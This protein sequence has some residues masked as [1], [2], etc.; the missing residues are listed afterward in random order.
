MR[1]YFGTVTILFLLM[2]T[3]LASKAFS[4]SVIYD[5]HTKNINIAIKERVEKVHPYLVWAD[6]SEGAKGRFFSLV[7]NKGWIS[8]IV[9]VQQEAMD[10]PALGDADIGDLPAECPAGHK[11]FLFMVAVQNG[12]KPHEIEAWKK[13]SIFPL[14][15]EAAKERLPGQSGFVPKQDRFTP[16]YGPTLNL[17]AGGDVDQEKQ[18]DSSVNQTETEKPDIFKIEGQ[19]IF[20]ANANAGRLQVIDWSDPSEPKL[21]SSAEM[22]GNPKEIYSLNGN[23]IIL[24]QSSYGSSSVSNITMVNIYGFKDNE[25]HLKQS[26]K[27]DGLFLESRR[28]GELIYVITKVYEGTGRSDTMP[29]EGQRSMIWPLQSDL[30]VTALKVTPQGWLV[31]KAQKQLVGIPDNA[32]TAIFPNYLLY[33]HVDYAE[34]NKISLITIFD[35][36]NPNNPL[37]QPRH[38]KVPGHIPSEFHMDVQGNIL[39]VVSSPASWQGNKGSTLSIFDLSETPPKLLGKLDGIAPGEDLY[40]TRFET[41]KAYVV[42]YERKDP[43]WVIGLSDSA[44]P[45]ILGHLQV[46][47]WSEK[48]FIHDSKLLGMGVYDQPLPGENRPDDWYRRVAVSLFDVEDPSTPELLDRVVPLADKSIHTSSLALSDERALLLD[49]QRKLC[50]FPVEI[51]GKD[52]GSYLQILTLGDFGLEDRGAVKVPV[53]LKRALFLDDDLLGGLGGFA[54]YTIDW[55]GEPEIA[56][57]LELA[58]DYS[59]LE[60]SGGLVWAA[61]KAWGNNLYKIYGF[62]PDD[63][64]EPVCIFEPESDFK[65]VKINGDMALLY[66]FSPFRITLLDLSSGETSQSFVLDDS[67]NG[68]Y[69]YDNV[70]FKDNKIYAVKTESIGPKEPAPALQSAIFPSP[71]TGYNLSVMKAWEVKGLD[72]KPLFLFETSVPGKPVGITGQG[73]IIFHEAYKGKKVYIHLVSIEDGKAVLEKSKDF[74]CAEWSSS[75]VLN[76]SDKLFMACMPPESYPIVIMEGTQNNKIVQ[77]KPIP[78]VKPKLLLINPRSLD[79]EASMVINKGVNI[80]ES[81]EDLVFLVKQYGYWEPV[82]LKMPISDA[83]SHCAVYKVRGNSF[84]MV[85]EFDAGVCNGRDF[86]LSDTMLFGAY[87]LK[88]LKGFE[89]F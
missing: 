16:I 50:V 15:V 61:S 25:L 71:D 13:T 37:P 21:L 73:K 79:V 45:E 70:I 82:T 3:G 20:Y 24:Q 1:R 56:G 9:P 89:L 63:L 40:A 6:F 72:Q 38:V 51:Y 27:I 32:V 80:K 60:Y 28:R 52:Y 54:F 68:Y 10:I 49:W 4:W 77:K 36:S 67:E 41:D 64:K 53:P 17:A 55:F 85:K 87:G 14:S 26:I 74:D 43:L 48:L 81:F 44:N 35:I 23:Y 57:S 65:S 83:G 66:S 29:G 84:E 12:H 2:L 33:A 47:G 7:A 88:G 42:T 78:V 34:P 30:L 39:R 22:A 18:E 62:E 58:R 5:F 69:N 76:N 19:K 31:K 8:G 11:C 75:M 59:W 86:A 46:P